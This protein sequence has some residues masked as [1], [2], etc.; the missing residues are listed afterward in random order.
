M[1][2]YVI[3]HKMEATLF[4]SDGEMEVEAK[5][6]A[7]SLCPQPPPLSSQ[8]PLLPP[9]PLLNSTGVNTPSFPPPLFSVPEVSTQLRDLGKRRRD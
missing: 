9:V 4:V 2:L 7:H 5:I 3:F 6:L 1:C 8:P